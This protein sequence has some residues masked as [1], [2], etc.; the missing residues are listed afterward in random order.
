MPPIKLSEREQKLA[1][2]TLGFFVFYIF[3]Q[4]LLTPKWDEIGKLKGKA[5]NARLELEIAEGKLRIL[6]GLEKR[7]G[8]VS[9]K[10]EIPPEERALE[11]LRALAQA[12]SK[13]G[14]NLISIKPM[15]GE[16]K[17]PKFDLSCSGTYENLYDFLRIMRDLEIMVM[18]DSL[19]ISGGGSRKPELD[20][21]IV[22]TAYF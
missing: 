21:K 12:T 13:S 9:V 11:T 19:K 8:A 17:G 6:E 7:V 16:E 20:V 14:L 18:I 1:V 5:Q 4:F 10:R 3:Y 22:L 2:V 15:I